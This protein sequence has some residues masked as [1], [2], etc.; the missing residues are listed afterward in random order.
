MSQQPTNQGLAHVLALSHQGD[1]RRLR[2]G[3]KAV[4]GVVKGSKRPGKRPGVVFDAILRMRG[5]EPVRVMFVWPG[6]LYVVDPEGGEII[7]EAT[8]ADMAVEAAEAVA[9]MARK[10][11]G[12][13]LV[14]VLYQPSQSHRLEASFWPDG[15]LRVHAFK[16]GKRGEL[17]AE[18]LPG[19]PGELNP[20]FRSLSPQE[21]APRLT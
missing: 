6:R 19:K 11:K 5:R 3:A 2:L 15:V 1:Q 7:R 16:G 12:L 4:A 8:A 13:A 18:S 14:R 17:L 10:A 20:Q 21:L 9:F